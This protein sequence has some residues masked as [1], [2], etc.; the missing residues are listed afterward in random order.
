MIKFFRNVKSHVMQD[1]DEF[2]AI[3]LSEDPL[4]DSE[5]IKSKQSCQTIDSVR[6]KVNTKANG[7]SLVCVHH[8][9]LIPFFEL[10]LGESLVTYSMLYDHDVLDGDFK[11]LICYDISMYP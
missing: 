2:K 1:I 9:T 7:L 4:Q 3:L 11:G 6:M 8:E 5:L 10:T